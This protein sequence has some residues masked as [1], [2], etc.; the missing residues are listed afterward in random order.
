MDSLF[1]SP[2]EI[3][4]TC[5]SVGKKKA[6]LSAPKM[7]WLGFLAGMFIAFAGVAA[8]FANVYVNK[9][10]GAMVFPAGLAMVLLAGSELFTGNCLMTAAL[11]RH[12]ITAGAMLKNW[13]LVYLGNLIGAVFVSALTVFGGTFDNAV[14]EALMAT[15]ASKASLSFGAA[16]LR[17][18]LCN[19]LVC[20]AVWMSF[21]AKDMGGKVLAMYFPIMA[22][23][24]SGFEHSIANMFY[25]PAGILLTARTGADAISVSGAILN[26]LLP[27]TL[28]NIVGGAG[29]VAAGYFFVYLKRKKN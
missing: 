26:N 20:V 22:F 7:L 16:F 3:A 9:L 14:G 5:V 1:L 21:G 6:G 11:L 18:I 24:V 25:L 17:G 10:A 23:V 8:T 27:V 19:I 12:E 2:A 15:A 28:G 13:G 29:I 4:E